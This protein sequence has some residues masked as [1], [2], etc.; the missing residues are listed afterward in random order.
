MHKKTPDVDRDV[1]GQPAKSASAYN[2]NSHADGSSPTQPQRWRSMV[3]LIYA[4]RR[5]RAL[6]HANDHFV[7][8]VARRHVT[9]SRSYRHM[10]AP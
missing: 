3:L 1:S 4:M 2:T 6:S 5:W 7:I 10:R 9:L 8:L